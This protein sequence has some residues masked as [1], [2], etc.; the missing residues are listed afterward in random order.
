VARIIP[1]F[2]PG[3]RRAATFFGWFV[4]VVGYMRHLGRGLRRDGSQA[5]RRAGRRFR[6]RR[7]QVGGH[8]RDVEGHALAVFVGVDGQHV[9]HRDVQFARDAVEARPEGDRVV[10][11]F[12]PG[13]RAVADVEDDLALFHVF[14][15]NRGGG[16]D[17]DGQ[18]RRVAAVRAPFVN[19]AQQVR[20]G[21]DVWHGVIEMM[22]DVTRQCTSIRLR[23]RK[24]ACNGGGA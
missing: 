17:L 16:V 14:H 8:R 15:R 1:L 19:G 5:R 4:V 23:R 2:D 21:G 24:L 18:V 6:C 9:V 3:Q 10:V 22:R 13:G 11:H 20:L 7:G 12:Q